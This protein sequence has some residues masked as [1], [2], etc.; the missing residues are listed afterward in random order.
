MKRLLAFVLM[1]TALPLAA[2]RS[3]PTAAPPYL[4]SP[5]TLAVDASSAPQRIF[6]AKL[7]IP[8]APGELTLLYPKWIPGEHMPDGPI[9]D[10]AGLHFSANGQAI[11]WHRDVVD[12]FI[13]R[14]TVPPGATTLDVALDFLSPTETGGF[15]AGSSATAMMTVISWNQLLLYPAGPPADKLTYTASLKLPD[16]W[17]FGTALPLSDNKATVLNDQPASGV[18]Q[19]APATLERLVDSPVIAGLH[20]KA[21]DLGNHDGLHHEI[22]AAAD[23]DAALQISPELQ[24]KYENLVVEAGTLY[25]ARHYRD[26][27]FLLSLS[28]HVAH[29]GLEHNESSDDR[30]PEDGITDPD[31]ILLHATLLPHEYTHS[32]NGKYRR[33]KDLATPDFQQPMHDDLL[34]VYEGLTQYLGFVL[35]GRSGLRDPQTERDYLAETAA[36]LDQRS[37]RSWRPLQDTADD[38]QVLYGSPSYWSDYRRDTDFYDEAILLW[39]DVDTTIRDLTQNKKSLDDFCHIFHGG[40]SG[41]PGVKPYTFEEV[42]ATLNQVAP[43][44]WAKFLRTRLDRVGQGAPLDGLTASGWKIEYTDQPSTLWKLEAKIGRG[45]GQNLRFSLGLMLD[46]NGG[47]RDVVVGSP[48]YNAGI[49]PGMRVVAVNSRGYSDDIMNT[50]LRTAKGGSEPIELLVENSGWFKTYK[51][52]YHG[53]PRYPHLVPDGRPDVLQQILA[54][55]ATH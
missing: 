48:A 8:V 50:A 23:S 21:I 5:I 42:V 30:I 26:Y 46:K 2:Q 47:V 39:L 29:F 37:G 9:V 40:E 35:T 3:K 20:Y 27:H 41:Q 53:G 19:F 55:H 14:V 51:V 11:A 31:S 34:W 43:N 7:S 33:P 10:L 45:P 38:A 32:W 54:P 18:I 28:D 16:G 24:K 25:G 52:D 22:D 44:D 13:F 12:P 17:K 1:L 15:S 36:Y 6:H 4:S 49:G